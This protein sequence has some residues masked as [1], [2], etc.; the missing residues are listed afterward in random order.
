[1]LERTRSKYTMEATTNNFFRVTDTMFGDW[2]EIPAPLLG[3]RR[4]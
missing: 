1:M 4:L 2:V 3:E